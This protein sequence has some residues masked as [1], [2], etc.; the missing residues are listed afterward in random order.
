MSSFERSKP[1]NFKQNRNWGIRNNAV[2]KRDSKNI[3]NKFQKKAVAPNI[4]KDFNNNNENFKHKKFNSNSNI[5]D[6]KNYNETQNKKLIQS[7]KEADSHE[8]DILSTGSDKKVLYSL[9]RLCGGYLCKYPSVYSKN[10]KYLICSNENTIK[11]YT[12]TTGDCVKTLSVVP[13]CGGHTNEITS[14]AIDP[15]DPSLLYSSS[16]DGTIKIWNLDKA[17]LLETLDLKCPIYHMMV[18]PKHSKDIYIFTEISSFDSVSLNLNLFDDSEDDKDDSQNYKSNHLLRIHRVNNEGGQFELTKILSL[19]SRI[20]T[21]AIGVDGKYL[22]VACGRNYQVVNLEIARKDLRP[23]E[24][25]NHFHSR[26]ITSIAINS[27][28][29]CVAIGDELGMITFSYCLNERRPKFTKALTHWHAH[30]VTC[31]AFT[32]DGAYLLSGGEESVLVFW[33]V[34]TGQRQY[35]PRLGGAEITFITISPNQTIIAVGLGDNTIKVLSMNREL[36]QV[37][38]GLKYVPKNVSKNPL[39][40][41]LIVE[42]R[43]QHIVLPASPGNLQWYDAHNSRHIMEHEVSLR[44]LVSRT[45][46]AEITMPHVDYVAFSEYGDWMVTVDSRN[47][48]KTTPDIYLKFWEFSDHAKSYVLNTLVDHP[49]NDCFITS[50]A[51]RPTI[52][53][54]E[55]KSKVA[56]PASN[57]TTTNDNNKSNTKNK[58]EGI[59]KQSAYNW[60]CT[61]VG[62]Y[63][64]ETPQKAIFSE[65]GSVLAIALGPFI[66]LWDPI[67]NEFHGELSHV[68]LTLTIKNLMFLSQSSPYLVSTTKDYL[69]LWDLESFSIR[70]Q[71]RIHVPYMSADKKSSKFAVAAICNNSTCVLVFDPQ[72]AIPRSIRIIVG[73]ILGLVYLP[74]NIDNH[75]EQESSIVFMDEDCRLRVLGQRVLIDSNNKNDLENISDDNLRLSDTVDC[76]AF[77]SDIFGTSSSCQTVDVGSH[78]P[79]KSFNKN[80]L[81]AFN[82]PSHLIPPVNSLFDGYMESLLVPSKHKIDDEKNKEKEDNGELSEKENYYD[83]N[84]DYLTEFFLSRIQNTP[85][86]LEIPLS[87]DNTTLSSI[88]VSS[89]S[90]AS[91]SSLETPTLSLS[92]SPSHLSKPRTLPSQITPN[93]AS[94]KSI[95]NNSKK[96][97][98]TESPN[99]V[100]DNTSK[101]AKKPKKIK[102]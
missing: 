83:K 63:R 21:S 87:N 93:G 16:L 38:H 55:R 45:D 78:I 73:P 89:M 76:K 34:E 70:W 11:V 51:F 43:N 46:E 47:D 22:V 41:G 61:F 13:Q 96:R 86:T 56:K 74:K 67:L 85:S 2:D 44:T 5:N 75:I 19:S 94:E 92:L 26:R 10:S 95:S 98:L 17:V 59:P 27:S 69:Y 102:T 53:E 90:S 12:L 99:N 32:N 77:F 33:Q 24:W 20:S 62:S 81:D 7:I 79:I 40:A 25:P 4:R 28:R 30:G 37:I 54:L 50:V 84:F 35:V 1:S 9:N 65:D 39:T 66:T 29:P 49:H 72:T 82:A 97:K 18:D 42:P 3:S 100:N 31:M 14:L 57:T 101:N 15:N 64:Q 91:S 36:R 68:P 8:K 60:V 48:K 23:V 52:W 58:D 80:I 71:Y 88:E 6:H